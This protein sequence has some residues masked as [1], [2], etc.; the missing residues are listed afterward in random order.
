MIKNKLHTLYMFKSHDGICDLLEHPGIVLLVICIM[1][2]QILFC[3][4][5][6]LIVECLS[7]RHIVMRG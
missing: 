5:V 1:Q 3:M 7:M 6:N 2:M 4:H